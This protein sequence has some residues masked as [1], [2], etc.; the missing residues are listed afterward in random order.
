MHAACNAA[1]GSQP[2]I[3]ACCK[4]G[5]AWGAAGRARQP[6]PSPCELPARNRQL[7]RSSLRFSIAERPPP[8]L[9][10]ASSPSSGAGAAF[11]SAFAL[12]ITVYIEVRSLCQLSDRQGSPAL[13]GSALYW[14]RAILHSGSL[15]GCYRLCR[16][17][18]QRAERTAPCMQASVGTGASRSP[19]FEAFIAFLCV[20]A[21]HRVLC[22]T[23][24]P[25]STLQAP[26]DSRGSRP[27]SRKFRPLG[28]CP[29]TDPVAAQLEQAQDI[30]LPS[31]GASAKAPRHTPYS[32]L[33]PGPPQRLPTLGTR[34]VS[35]HGCSSW[36]TVRPP[37]RP[38]LQPRRR[39]RR[40]RRQPHLTRRLRR[41]LSPHAGA[42]WP[43]M[44]FE[45]DD[46]ER[47]FRRHFH[48]RR[49]VQDRC[50]AVTQVPG[51]AR[52]PCTCLPPALAAHCCRCRQLL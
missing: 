37:G 5:G 34:L 23:P 29:C 19:C 32:Q 17:C 4:Q 12:P 16:D 31:S 7:T 15:P 21:A 30:D 3:S 40:R 20:G 41:T 18:R 33:A 52:Q 11:L 35:A 48:S 22:R 8:P 2:P 10:K 51:G 47:Q 9:T 39:R 13:A 46:A 45:G 27:R 28:P 42:R 44:N 25:S 6:G 38:S 36:P 49:V 14:S 43:A 1:D 24:R 26:S 50:F